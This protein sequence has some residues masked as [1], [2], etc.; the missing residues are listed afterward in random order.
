MNRFYGKIGYAVQ[1]EVR[2]GVW[3]DIITERKYFGELVDKSWREQQ[4]ADQV[5]DN[6]KLNTNIEIIADPFA[7]DHFS[8]IRYVCYGG[9][10]WEVSSVKAERPRIILS[11]GGLYNGPT[12]E[13]RVSDE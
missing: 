5:H 12:P 11:I 9:A 6:L 7:I 2:T 3:E 13:D 10:R 1:K 4:A 8:K